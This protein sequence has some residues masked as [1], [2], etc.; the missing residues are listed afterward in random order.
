LAV[1]AASRAHALT[2]LDAKLA[3]AQTEGHRL[4][5]ILVL[6]ALVGASLAA[7]LALAERRMTP[8]LAARRA[9]AVAVA[10]VVAAAFAGG[11][12]RFGAPWTAAHHAWR[13]F[14]A[15]QKDFG[16]DLNSRLFQLSNHGRLI[17]WKA[18]AH[19]FEHAPVVGTGAGT[20]EVWWARHRPQGIQIRNAHS[21]YLQ[22]MGELGIVG[23]LLVL[24]IVLVPLMAAIRARRQP[25]VPFAAAALA[26]WAVH[27][28]VDWDWQVPA[29]TLPALA[30]A[31]LVCN[32]APGRA[33]RLGTEARIG[34][35]AAAVAIAAFGLVAGIGNQALA[36][37]NKALD[38][39][40]YAKADQQAKRAARWAPWLA[41]P[42]IIQ[43]QIDALGQDRTTA[44]RDFRKAIA[45]DPH[46]YLAW[47]GLA[48]VTHGDARREAVAEVEALDP[49][50]DEA[51]ELRTG[52]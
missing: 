14:A 9:F 4:A 11:V 33:L 36:D 2:A 34:M 40:N 32:A 13:S 41:E 43:G 7:V 15:P 17:Q 16:N 35:A 18:A 25:L 29:V 47:Y 45:K 23:L 44:E 3:G 31:T 46:N 12:A 22:T 26:A 1:F 5:G 19:Q 8:S 49:L 28:G 27:A 52:S 39:Q 30:L 10:A 38:G 24:G 48:G 50:S 20:F 37:S 21:L 6:L 51:K 42:W